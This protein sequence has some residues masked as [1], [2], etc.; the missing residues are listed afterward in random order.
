MEVVERKLKPYIIPKKLII[1]DLKMSGSYIKQN[2][3]NGNSRSLT[4]SCPYHRR[5]ERA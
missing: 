1:N 3:S 4:P 5:K 2:N